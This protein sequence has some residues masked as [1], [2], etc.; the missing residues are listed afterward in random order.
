M[1]RPPDTRLPMTILFLDAD[2]A[3]CAPLAAGLARHVAES[4]GLEVDAY[5]AGVRPSHVRPEVRTMLREVGAPTDGLHAKPVMAVPLDEL[6]L[7]VRLAPG[8]S[9]TLVKPVPTLDWHLPDPSSAPPAERMDAYRA[10]RDELIR[11]LTL[12]FDGAAR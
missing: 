5:S 3:A 8:L 9:V 2:D 7:L 11:R 12:H 6:D 1:P 4:R 10:A